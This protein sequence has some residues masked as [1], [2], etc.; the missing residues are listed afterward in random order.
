MTI[1]TVHF[2]LVVAALF[3]YTRADNVELLFRGV[4]EDSVEAVKSAIE[5]GADINVV[6]SGGQTPLMMSCLAGSPNV[7]SLLFDLGA[8]S[9]IGEKDGYT[10][11]HGVAFQG[12]AAVARIAIEK[13]KLE[14][15]DYHNDGYAPHHR[16]CWGSTDRHFEVF[17]V[18]HEGGADIHGSARKM[19]A[20]AWT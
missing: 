14:V 12:R 20:H 16:A 3:G 7:A 18:L 6:G 9:S 17:K 5:N 1:K 15:N 11:L 2:A 19:A 4:Q 10:C 13:G 8:D